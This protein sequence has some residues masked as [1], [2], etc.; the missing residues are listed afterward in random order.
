[1]DMNKQLIQLILVAALGPSVSL[2]ASVPMFNSSGGIAFAGQTSAYGFQFTPT[3]NIVV[4]GLGFFDADADGL[5]A[6]HGVGIWTTA[7]VLLASIT[8]TTGNSSL[9][10]PTV[11]QG[12]FRYANIAD[13]ALTAGTTYVLGAQTAG[14]DTWY[15]FGSNLSPSSLVNV[16]AN[17]MYNPS[18]GFLVPTQSVGD[19]FAAGSF[20]AHEAEAT[21]PEPQTAALVGLGLLAAVL[22]GKRRVG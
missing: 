16:A 18:S 13:L 1:M 12:Q 11:N 19:Q 9:L 2:A 17:G 6:A 15:S 22:S 7:G 14:L 5:V 4:D 10:G 21:V 8:V 3:A 20:T